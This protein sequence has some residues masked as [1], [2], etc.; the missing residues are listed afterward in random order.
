MIRKRREKEDEWVWIIGD[1]DEL[2]IW[3]DAEH[4]THEIFKRRYASALVIEEVA[5]KLCQ[6]I[7]REVDHAMVTL[8]E[9]M[10]KAER[11]LEAKAAKAAKDE[12]TGK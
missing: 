2:K 6:V 11:S 10:K 7:K 9:A 4:I 3:T 8:I 12:E 1:S 5:E